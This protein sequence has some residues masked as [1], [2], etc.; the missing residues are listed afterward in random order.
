MGSAE[1]VWVE[2]AVVE[3]GVCRGCRVMCLEKEGGKKGGGDTIRYPSFCDLKCLGCILYSTAAESLEF[4]E[5][6]VPT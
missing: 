1:G 4:I 6:G 2:V 3:L 5:G